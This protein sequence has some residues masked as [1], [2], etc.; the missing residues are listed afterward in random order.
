MLE[1]SS[2]KIRANEPKIRAF[3]PSEILTFAFALISEIFSG[4]NIKK[5]LLI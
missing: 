1:S 2:E 3:Q 4:V 5:Y